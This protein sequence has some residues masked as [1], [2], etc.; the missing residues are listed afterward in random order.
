M[1]DY[2][3]CDLIFFAVVLVLNHLGLVE[4]EFYVPKWLKTWLESSVQ[5]LPDTGT[6]YEEQQ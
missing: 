1:I 5:D 2:Q 3:W 4:I 6:F